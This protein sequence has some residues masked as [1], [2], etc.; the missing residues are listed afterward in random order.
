MPRK[1]LVRDLTGH[2]F[3]RLKVVSRAED[4]VYPS[5]KCTAWLCRCSCGVE[6]VIRGNDLKSGRTRS[7]GCLNVDSSTTHG[8]RN[9]RVY[10]E[11]A[12]M[13]E[14]VSKDPKYLSVDLCNEWETSFEKFYDWAV[15]NG[16]DDTLTLDRIDG[17]KGY[18]PEN[19]R[20]VG[21]KE[22]IRN[23]KN[24]LRLKDGTSLADYAESIG[25]S[26]MV[27]GHPSKEYERLKRQLKKMEV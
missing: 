20:W 12:G 8:M 7:C 27:D 9:T 16:Y 25:V 18:C 15:H 19:C 13:K 1:S 10:R 24:T 6:K 11:W 5:G 22:Q 21:Y 2:V 17:T 3:G 14:R 4:I 26:P 23:R